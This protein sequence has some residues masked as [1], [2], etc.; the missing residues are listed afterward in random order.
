M[1]AGNLMA[2]LRP[3]ETRADES[4]LER[5][6]V[7]RSVVYIVLGTLASIWAIGSLVSG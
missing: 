7:T 5:A 1:A 2:L 4:D 3:P 6:P